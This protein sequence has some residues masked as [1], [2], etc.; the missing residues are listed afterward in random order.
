M[1]VEENVIYGLTVRGGSVSK[2]DRASRVREALALVG[3]SAYGARL[4]GALSGGQRQRVA[5]ARAIVK[6]PRVLLLDEPLSALDVK[7]RETSRSS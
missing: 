5:M 1:T 3:L 7:L 2:Q 6:R 4:P